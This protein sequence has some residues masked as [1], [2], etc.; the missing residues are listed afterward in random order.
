MRFLEVRNG[1]F[2]YRR[3]STCNG[4]RVTKRVS[5]RTRDYL[6]AQ[7]IALDLYFADQSDSPIVVDRNPTQKPTSEHTVTTTVHEPYFES[8]A[9]Q[10]AEVLPSPTESKI[11]PINDDSVAVGSLKLS[12]AVA[13]YVQEAK[14]NWSERETKTQQALFDKFIKSVGDADIHTLTK[15]HAVS[16]KATLKNSALTINKKLYKLQALFEYLHSHYEITNIFN[17]LLIKRVSPSTKRISY[18]NSEAQTL[19]SFA[20]GLKQKHQFRKF[21]VYLSAYTGARANELCQLRKSDVVTIKGHVCI[22]INDDRPDKSLKTPSARRIVPLH[23]QILN[24]GFMEYIAG[25]KDDQRL[26]PQ[27]TFADGGY[28]KSYTAWFG[29]C[30]PVKARNLHELRHSVA[31]RMKECNVSLQ[32]AAAIMGHTAGGSMTFDLYGSGATIPVELLHG[33]IEGVTYDA[34]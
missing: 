29:R 28:S 34:A 18:T 15:H 25:I 11:E 31:T 4:K 22:S 30:N 2:Y 33:A 3:V 9:I 32:V 27:L 24:C 21:L 6:R 10:A 23:S 5:L 13:M 7:K 20:D 1:I 8:E 12:A 26:F 16:Y 17:G 19:L 14:T